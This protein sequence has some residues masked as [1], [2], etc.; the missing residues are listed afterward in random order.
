[1]K[2]KR[3]KLISGGQKILDDLKEVYEIKDSPEK[4]PKRGAVPRR[5]TR[6]STEISVRMDGEPYEEVPVQE[7]DESEAKELI[8]AS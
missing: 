4:P 8:P 5:Q 6:T 2:V 3:G 1:M 7:K